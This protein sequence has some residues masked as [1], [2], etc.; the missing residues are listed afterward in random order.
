M[1]LIGRLIAAGHVGL[2]L[3]FADSI[4]AHRPPGAVTPPEAAD[5]LALNFDE[6]GVRP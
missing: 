1:L 6:A 4:A 2:G 5:L 3:E